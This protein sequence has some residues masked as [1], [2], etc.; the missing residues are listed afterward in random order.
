MNGKVSAAELRNTAT[1][2]NTEAGNLKDI[3]DKT[4][5]EMLKIGS[6]DVFSGTA[7]SELNDEFY[8]LSEK[9]SDYYTAVESCT[10][11]LNNV[12]QKYDDFE[13]SITNNF[14]SN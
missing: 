1:T 13:K 12:A 5:Q 3:L 6:E 10:K 8:A 11:Y 9:F 2:L 14:G 4:K 7:A